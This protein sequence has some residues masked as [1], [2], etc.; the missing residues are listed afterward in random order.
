MLMY[1]HEKI[2]EIYHA[3]TPTK[4]E[5]RHSKPIMPRPPQK[6]RISSKQTYPIFSLYDAA[7]LCNSMNQIN[8]E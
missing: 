7:I 8:S 2:K 4:L 1:V 3:S 6:K 5:K